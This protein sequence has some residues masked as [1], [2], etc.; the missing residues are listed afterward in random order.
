MR[1]SSSLFVLSIVLWAPA[2]GREIYVDN[3]AGD[4]TFTGR[5]DRNTG[6][7]AGPVRTSAKAL[8]LAS[9]GDVIVLADNDEPYR[10]SFSL[11]GNRHSGYP[12][13]AFTI[14]GN[15]ATLDGSVP[16]PQ[17]A[18]EHYRGAVFR[19]RPRQM[20]PQQLFINDRPAVRVV[21]GWTSGSPPRLRP[22]QWCVHEGYI[23]FCVE[24]EKLPDNYG[25]TY[26]KLQ[27]GITLY[28]VQ[29]VTISNL[30]VQGFRIDGINAQNSARDVYIYEVTARGNGRAG[31]T[32]GGASKVTIKV[33][34]LG[35]NGQAQ[36]LTLPH[37]KTFLRETQMFSNTA[38]AWVDRGGSVTADGQSIEGGIDDFQP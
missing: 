14:A 23:Y 37:S 11:V 38:P 17:G 10:E 24:P 15:G 33:G 22:L 4:D 1:I 13:Q 5:Q 29:G 2:A 32:V 18:W 20:G 12:Q 36:L 31:I 16:V 28:H 27:T 34:V 6:D 9:S 19:F 21:G 3:V 35:N 8:R 26:A 30:T 25:L 7:R